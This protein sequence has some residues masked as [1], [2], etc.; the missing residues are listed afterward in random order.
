MTTETI[1]QSTAPIDLESLRREY[2]DSMID[3]AAAAR[4]LAK[5]LKTNSSNG[6]PSGLPRSGKSPLDSSITVMLEALDKH[7]AA[8][9]SYFYPGKGRAA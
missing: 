8:A 6:L 2:F 9:N 3:V 4:Y 7:E 1:A 5:F